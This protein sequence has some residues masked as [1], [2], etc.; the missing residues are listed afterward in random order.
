MPRQA[1]P[2]ACHAAAIAAVLFAVTTAPTQGSGRT[3]ADDPALP[4]PAGL[5]ELP[6]LADL[7][8]RRLLLADAVA[9]AEFGTATLVA[10]PAG[11][12]ELLDAVAEHSVE[13]GLPVPTGVGFFRAQIAAAEHV[14][15]GLH[16]RWR[17]RPALLPHPRSDLAADVRPRLDL[18]TPRLLRLLKETEPVRGVPRRCTPALAEARR[19]AETRAGL[20][21]LHRDALTLA[22]APVCAA[23]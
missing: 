19:A 4:G 16:E 8:V 9:A 15:R 20:D 11:Q 7:T 17:A 5:E 18:L 3:A 22:L 12:R 23:E 6:E 2:L 14:R 21:R 13:I 10:D 1:L